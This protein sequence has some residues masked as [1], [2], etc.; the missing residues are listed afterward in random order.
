M[1]S[2]TKQSIFKEFAGLLEKRVLSGWAVHSASRDLSNRTVRL[3]WHKGVSYGSAYSWVCSAFV[4][5]TVSAKAYGQLRVTPLAGPSPAAF[6]SQLPP[7]TTLAVSVSGSPAGGRQVVPSAAAAST[8]TSSDCALG[9]SAPNVKQA[10]LS[11]GGPGEDDLGTQWLMVK[12]LELFRKTPM[13]PKASKMAE[14]VEG[15]R[16]GEGSFGIVTSCTLV[17]SGQRV[18]VKKL[19]EEDKSEFLHE[20]AVLSRLRHSNVTRLLDVAVHPSMCLVFVYA[21]RNLQQ[22]LQDDT[23]PAAKWLEVGMQI[24]AGLVYLHTKYIVHGD[25]KPANV[26]YEEPAGQAGVATIVDLGNSLVC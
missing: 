8:G 20:V 19:K 16:L 23:F 24:L 12:A 26:C 14:L 5:S 15:E 17:A 2:D 1:P 18:A 13:C 6:A 3:F 9:D 21:G 7:S 22:Q 10:R 11:A 4:S 25:M